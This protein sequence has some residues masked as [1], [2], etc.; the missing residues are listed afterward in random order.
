MTMTTEFLVDLEPEELATLGRFL[1]RYGSC[2]PTLPRNGNNHRLPSAL[3]IMQASVRE[4]I[5]TNNVNAATGEVSVLMRLSPDEA[6]AAEHAFKRLKMSEL[7]VWLGDENDSNHVLMA[8]WK[9]LDVI[10]PVEVR[11]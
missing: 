3:Q 10:G 1:E 2:L 9:V 8:L 4:A 11:L 5:R 6:A 7:D